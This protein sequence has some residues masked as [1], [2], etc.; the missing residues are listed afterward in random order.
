M[1]KKKSTCLYLDM[2]IAE[3]A[4]QS[5]LNISKISENALIQAIERL[6]GPEQEAGPDGRA[7]VL[8]RS[9]NTLQAVRLACQEKKQ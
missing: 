4:R 8:P 5:G 9:R 7:R 3:T 1:S 2:E 6:R